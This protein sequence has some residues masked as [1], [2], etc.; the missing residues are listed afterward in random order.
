[1]QTFSLPYVYC[2]VLHGLY[3][4]SKLDI[5]SFIS[6]KC[7]FY[8]KLKIIF[9]WDKILIFLSYNKLQDK[10]YNVPLVVL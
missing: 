3:F 9:S 7:T 2:M 10:V 6:L 5:N 1:M 4:I 8:Q